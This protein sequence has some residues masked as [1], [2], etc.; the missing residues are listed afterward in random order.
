MFQVGGFQESEDSGASISRRIYGTISLLPMNVSP[1]SQILPLI[2]HPLLLY[3]SRGP[4]NPNL[5][6]RSKQRISRESPATFSLFICYPCGGISV[7]I[8][9]NFKLI[10]IMS[11]NAVRSFLQILGHEQPVNLPRFLT[12]FFLSSAD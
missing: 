4:L 5:S 8:K 12:M 10:C 1:P 9:M 2:L 7:K 11:A 6:F 3:R